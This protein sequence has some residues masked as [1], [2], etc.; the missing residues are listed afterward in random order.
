M[1]LEKASLEPMLT[2][3]TIPQKPSRPFGG[4]RPTPSDAPNV[5]E[6][7]LAVGRAKVYLVGD[8]FAEAAPLAGMPD[9]HLQ[10]KLYFFGIDKYRPVAIITEIVTCQVYLATVPPP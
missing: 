10:V 2:L 9:P 1:Q 6:G 7:N 4:M 3:K 8:P 5:W